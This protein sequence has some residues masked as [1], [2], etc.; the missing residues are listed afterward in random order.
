MSPKQAPE[1]VIE[2]LAL[3]AERFAVVI[4]IFALRRFLVDPSQAAPYLE[5]LAKEAGGGIH[6]ELLEDMRDELPGPAKAEALRFV[7][8]RLDDLGESEDDARR[9]LRALARSLAEDEG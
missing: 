4:S 5:R 8:G 7:R 1:S 3:D 2:P 6:G 9:L